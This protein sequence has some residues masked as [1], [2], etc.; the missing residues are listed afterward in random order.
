VFFQQRA[1][2]SGVEPAIDT[3]GDELQ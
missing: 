1:Q 3:L 2:P